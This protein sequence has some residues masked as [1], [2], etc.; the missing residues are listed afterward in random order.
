MSLDQ[1]DNIFS[2]LSFIG[3]LCLM[4]KASFSVSSGGR[5]M[6]SSML[7]MCWEPWMVERVQLWDDALDFAE[8]GILFVD[9]FLQFP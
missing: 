7:V 9:E 5:L 2:C 8:H 1:S 4:A 6:M 3:A